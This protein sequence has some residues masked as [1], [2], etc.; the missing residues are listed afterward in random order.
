MIE[1]SI[2]QVQEKNHAK[3]DDLIDR[4]ILSQY[5]EYHLCWASCGNFEIN[6]ENFSTIYIFSLTKNIFCNAQSVISFEDLIAENCKQFKITA[7]S[8]PCSNAIRLKI[9][10]LDDFNAIFTL[11]PWCEWNHYI[12]SVCSKVF[13]NQHRE[14]LD[15]KSIP[16]ENGNFCIA[17]CLGSWSCFSLIYLINELMNANSEISGQNKR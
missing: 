4:E 12:W 13:F 5:D 2:N 17:K 11:C 15:L 8:V 1:T 6:M 7:S 10:L 9:E 3:N 16:F 14:S